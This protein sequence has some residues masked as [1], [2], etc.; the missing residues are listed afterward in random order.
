MIKNGNQ[1][2]HLNSIITMKSGT[3]WPLNTWSTLKAMSLKILQL[4]QIQADL[5][6][7]DKHDYWQRKLQNKSLEDFEIAV[8]LSTFE[9]WYLKPES[10]FMVCIYV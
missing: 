2:N 8:L 1:L 6:N 3:G 5:F 4:K 7:S 9:N 10:C